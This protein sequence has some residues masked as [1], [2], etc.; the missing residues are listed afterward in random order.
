MLQFNQYMSQKK[1]HT[2]FTLTLIFH[3][4]KIQACANNSEIPSP[5]KIDEYIPC[6]YSMSTIWLL[7]I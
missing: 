6:R 3:Q 2:L 1:Y 7:I 4:K 5:T